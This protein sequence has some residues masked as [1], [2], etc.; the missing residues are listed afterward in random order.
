MTPASSPQINMGDLNMDSPVEE[1]LPKKAR[2]PSLLLLQRPH[3]PPPPPL[4][5]F[6]NPANAWC[7]IGIELTLL[8]P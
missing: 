5:T 1:P 3:P 6:P 7:S 8:R 2:P 4:P